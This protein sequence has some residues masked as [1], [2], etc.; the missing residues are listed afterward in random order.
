[1]EGWSEARIR[2]YQLIDKNPNAYYYRFNA[3]DC[4]Q[5]N[6]KWSKEEKDLFYKRMAEVG[7]NGQVW[8][9]YYAYG[10]D[11]V[12]AHA[13]HLSLSLSLAAHHKVGPLLDGDTWPSRLPMRQ[14]LSV[15]SASH[16]GGSQGCG[17]CLLISGRALYQ[18]RYWHVAR[19]STRTTRL[20][21]AASGFTC[22]REPKATPSRPSSS[23]RCAPS[24]VLCR[25]GMCS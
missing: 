6:G 19:L 25:G 12:S 4:P 20:T 3:P 24:L 8:S 18:G 23:V 13:D 15:R 21:R 17:S 22:V 1:M 7:V 10:C 11:L 14:L 16:S 5:R 9:C 2:A